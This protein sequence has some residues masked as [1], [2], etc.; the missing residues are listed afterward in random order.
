[1]EDA[2]HPSPTRILIPYLSPMT[3]LT[4]SIQGEPVR[5]GRRLQVRAEAD[6]LQIG[7]DLNALPAA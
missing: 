3:R 1:M 6:R 7:F 2:L 4:P 5:L